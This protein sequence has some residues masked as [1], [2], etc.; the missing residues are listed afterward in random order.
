MKI[1]A[2]TPADLPA[3]LEIQKEAY[4]AEAKIYDDYSIP[5]LKETLDGITSASKRGVI[6]KAE[7]DGALVGSVRVS[8]NND[9]CE[10]GRLSV[11]PKHQRRGI[12]SA[13]LKACESVFPSS[14]CYELFTGSKS[15]ANIS[16]YES[17]G[18][19]RTEARALSPQVTLIYLRK[20]KNP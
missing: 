11:S 2:A 5:P 4:Q 10:I 3:I 15:A 20:E 16:L 7:V 14:C 9:I 18:Y 17:L 1:S 6:L 19:R 12:G 13:L 8:L